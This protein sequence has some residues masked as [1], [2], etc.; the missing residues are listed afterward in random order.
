[1]PSILELATIKDSSTSRQVNVQSISVYKAVYHY[2]KSLGYSASQASDI[3]YGIG[4]YCKRGYSFDMMLT[5]TKL[6]VDQLSKFNDFYM[7]RKRVYKL[8]NNQLQI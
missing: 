1:M 3:A 4:G 5:T 2:A 8:V 6:D 7:T